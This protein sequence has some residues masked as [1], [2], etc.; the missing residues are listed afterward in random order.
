V[1]CT[2][3]F[4]V[5][6]TESSGFVSDESLKSVA[7]VFENSKFFHSEARAFVPGKPGQNFPGWPQQSTWR[8]TT[9]PQFPSIASLLAHM[10]EKLNESLED[11]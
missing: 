4:L 9:A 7:G 11:E 3:E 8:M 6:A 10:H 1:L 2:G 5:L